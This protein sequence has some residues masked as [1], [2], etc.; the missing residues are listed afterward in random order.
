MLV[1][2]M[3]ETVFDHIRAACKSVAHRAVHVKI[4]TDR[5]PRYAAG[6]PVDKVAVSELDATCH[7]LG[8]EKDTHG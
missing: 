5:I 4:D 6:L 7:Y 8:R 2:L 3:I 1:K